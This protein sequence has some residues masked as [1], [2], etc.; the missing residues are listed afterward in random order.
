MIDELTNSSAF[1]PNF[2]AKNKSY[3]MEVLLPVS[4]QRFE[5]ISGSSSEVLKELMVQSRGAPKPKPRSIYQT[6]VI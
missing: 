6:E 4:A 5:K 2:V 1:Q 3:L